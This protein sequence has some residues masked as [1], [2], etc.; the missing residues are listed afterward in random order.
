MKL[1]IALDADGKR[2]A[3]HPGERVRGALEI[4]DRA[5][6][7]FPSINA[8]FKGIYNIQDA[9]WHIPWS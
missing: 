2:Q 5:F 7:E 6:K 3:F 1:A 8:I 4:R 9:I